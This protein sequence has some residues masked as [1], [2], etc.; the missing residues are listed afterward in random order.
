MEL[1]LYSHIRKNF[2]KDTIDLFDKST[3]EKI[4]AY[5]SSIGLDEDILASVKKYLKDYNSYL[6]THKQ[7]KVALRYYQ[8]LA[9]YFTE[10]YYL[11]KD[12][13]DFDLLSKNALAYWMAT[14]SGKD[15]KSVV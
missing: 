14:G 9:L 4:E 10:V 3:Q 7:S 12:V 15:R 2:F 5:D 1:K 8:I 13:V 11:H 6:E